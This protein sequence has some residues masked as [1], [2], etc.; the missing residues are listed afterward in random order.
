MVPFRSG[1][2]WA[3]AGSGVLALV[4]T[5]V[6]ANAQ[7]LNPVDAQRNCQ[8][9]RNCQFS[10]GGSFRGCVSSYSCRTCRF[11]ASRCSVGSVSGKCQ[12]QVCDWG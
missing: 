11:V 7:A 5:L 9:L 4:F 2:V 6:Q 12:R 8:T 10:K 3:I 1:K